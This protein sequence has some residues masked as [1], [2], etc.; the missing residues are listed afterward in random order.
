[1][2]HQYLYCT[3]L[4]STAVVSS[5]LPELHTGSS[6]FCWT[7]K[8]GLSSQQLPAAFGHQ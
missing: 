8:S 1:L 3:I 6:I 5:I 2:N 4:G 7:F